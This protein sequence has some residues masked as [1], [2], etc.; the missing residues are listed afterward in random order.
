MAMLSSIVRFAPR[1]PATAGGSDLFCIRRTLSPRVSASFGRN[2]SGVRPNFMSTNFIETFEQTAADVLD[3]LADVVVGAGL[4][5]ARR[6][7][8]RGRRAAARPLRAHGRADRVVVLH[9][10][11]A[12]RLGP[13]L[14]LRAGLLQA[15]HRPRPLR[16]RPAAPHREPALPRALR[17]DG[18]V[19]RHVPLRRIA[20]APTACSTRPRAHE[21][22]PLLPAARRLDGARG[23]RPPPLAR[24]ARRR[25]RLRGGARPTKP[26]ALN[27]HEGVGVSFKDHGEASRYFSYTRMAAE[28]DI[29]WRGET[30]HFRGAAWMDREFGTWTTTDDQKGWDW[31]SL[32]LEDDTELMV[33]HIRDRA[34]TPLDLLQRHL[35][36][37]RGQT[38]APRARGLR[39]R[40]RPNT[41][42]A[43]TPAPSTRAAGACACRASAWMSP[44]RPSSKIRS[45]TRAA[46]R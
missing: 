36:R 20:R 31:F 7:G 24:H 43:R 5:P 42:A 32:Q 6:D 3:G 29:T 9:G 14:R 12:D 44:S 4:D 16:R 45:W 37:R 13:S 19:A 23:A 22:A 17:R 33:Y 1:P 30:E 35:R 2:F 41:G 10:P 40:S 25:P 27:G 8:A 28:G 18:R 39:T 26:A 11:H 15:A 38:H 21:L 34:R 46:R